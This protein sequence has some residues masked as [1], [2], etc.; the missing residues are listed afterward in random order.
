VVSG[1]SATAINYAWPVIRL[2]DLYLIYAEA[3]NEAG[4]SKGE[5]LEYIDRVRERAGLSS[6]ELSWSQYSR[7]PDKPATL[8]GRREIIRRERTIEMAFEGS[9]YW[10]L[11]RWKK[12]VEDLNKPVTGWYVYG[13][14]N[15]TYYVPVTLA[16]PVF[17]MKDYFWPIA[18][19]EIQKNENLVQNLG[20]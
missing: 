17:T 2:A 20:Y 7:T 16:Q 18:V 15:D 13:D 10:D 5:V 4:G 19:N 6:V 1:T 14:T 8:E 12:A 11:R 9:G 3:L